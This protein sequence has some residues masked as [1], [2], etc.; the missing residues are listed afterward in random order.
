MLIRTHSPAIFFLTALLFGLMASSA[1]A[2]ST[3]YGGVDDST[4][5]GTT[6]SLTITETGANTYDVVWSMNFEGYEGSVG[7]HQY[8][9]HIAFKAFSDIS[10]VTLDSVAWTSLVSGTALYP[11]NV[12]NGG[13]DDGSSAGMVCVVLDPHV[14][15]TNGGEL[16][17]NFTVVGDLKLD[18]WSYRGKF[19]LENGW[20]ISE[21]ATPIPEPSAALVFAF[22]MVAASTRM[23]TRR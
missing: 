10:S 22:G 1:N 20:V 6:G 17:A 3:S 21:S 9:T 2:L 12:N 19:G 4:L 15:A 5:K 13:C 16:F 7:D 8:L 18:E 23:R 14:D 11:A